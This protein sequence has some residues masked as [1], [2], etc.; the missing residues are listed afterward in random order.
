MRAVL[1]FMCCLTLSGCGTPLEPIDAAM[2]CMP[3][4]VNYS[5]KCFSYF[6]NKTDHKKTSRTYSSVEYKRTTTTYKLQPPKKTFSHK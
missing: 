2:D 6:G 5:G 1:I 4:L 3:P